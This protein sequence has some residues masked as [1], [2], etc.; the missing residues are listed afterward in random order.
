[1]FSVQF[2]I[3]MGIY[4][5]GFAGSQTTAVVEGIKINLMTLR[6][7]HTHKP[8]LAS[9]NLRLLSSVLIKVVNGKSQARGIMITLLQLPS[10][11]P[12]DGGINAETPPKFASRMQTSTEGVLP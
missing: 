8:G 11:F 3:M 10:I 5:G 4:G 1:M 12:R 7:V 6:D 2:D 9:M